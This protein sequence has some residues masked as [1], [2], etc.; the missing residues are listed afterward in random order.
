MLFSLAHQDL[1]HLPTHFMR[2]FYQ[3]WIV[4]DMSIW[5]ASSPFQYKDLASPLAYPTGGSYEEAAREKLGQ[6]TRKSL[7]EVAY[8]NE[9]GKPF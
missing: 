3:F 1:S 4:F 8:S 5:T 9:C 2:L 7:R 6:R